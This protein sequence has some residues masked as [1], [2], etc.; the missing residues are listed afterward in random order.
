MKERILERVNPARREFLKKLLAGAAFATPVIA[1]FS[2]E[3]LDA[4]PAYFCANTAPAGPI[5]PTTPACNT[6][7]CAPVT[8]LTPVPIV[9]A[10]GPNP[11]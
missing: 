10:C 9:P 3:S 2:V 8:P 6:A 11:T 4:A 7:A 1:T 5:A